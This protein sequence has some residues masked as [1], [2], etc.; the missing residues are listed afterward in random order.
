MDDGSDDDDDE[1]M[2]DG[3]GDHLRYQVE[4]SDLDGSELKADFANGRY[5]IDGEESDWLVWHQMGGT[6][7]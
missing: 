4:Y 7:Q 3:E 1:Q 2:R 6:P 5:W